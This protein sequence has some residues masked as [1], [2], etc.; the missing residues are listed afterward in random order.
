[1]RRN[2][3]AKTIGY[4]FLLSL[5]LVTANAVRAQENFRVGRPAAA[6]TTGTL[7]VKTTYGESI[8]STTLKANA[9]LNLE[10]QPNP[11]YQNA[12]FDWQNKNLPAKLQDRYGATTDSASNGQ[13]RGLK[14]HLGGA[15]SVLGTVVGSV[16]SSYIPVASVAQRNRSS[17]PNIAIEA[18]HCPAAFDP[19]F[20]VPVR[21]WDI[22]SSE[23]VSPSFGPQWTVN[24]NGSI[25]DVSPYTGAER[26][27]Q[28]H[29][30]NER[31]MVNLRQ[32]LLTV[33]KFPPFPEGS[34][35]RCYHLIFDGSAG[36]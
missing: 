13:H 4:C 12:I 28:G 21:W 3:F 19:A 9:T 30:I 23:E 24:P 10:E 32:I 34:K 20:Q 14:A 29:A 26:G 35:V 1:M 15:F 17:E 36:I 16:A 8:P 33:G 25:Y 6:A 31:T 7:T 22:L 11:S 27:N 18:G 2:K 5:Q